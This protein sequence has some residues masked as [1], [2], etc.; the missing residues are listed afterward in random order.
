MMGP[1]KAP[2]PDGF[3]AG[4]FQTHWDLVG[5]CVTRAVLNFLDGGELVEG[6]NHTT[7]VLIPKVASP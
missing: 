5:P 3:T 1:N 7:I 2:G 4:F 6:I